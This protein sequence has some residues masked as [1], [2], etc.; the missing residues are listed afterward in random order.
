MSHIEGHLRAPDG[1]IV[2]AA[3]RFNELIVNPLIDGARDAL[4]RHGVDPARITTVRC[5]GAF[6]LPLTC[7]SLARSGRYAG[8]VA[9]GCVIR[10]A[11]AHFE[12]VSGAAAQ[13]LL[14]VSMDS[15]VPVAFG[16]LTVDT[17]DQAFERAGSKA[18]NK[19]AEAALALLEQI[20]LQ[21]QLTGVQGE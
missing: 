6:E 18:G 11:T 14:R 8:I 7:Q 21:R 16:V 9:L 19:G 12:Y 3:A 10:G 17:L 15:A 5:P 2:L 4:I 1:D 13:G 20:D